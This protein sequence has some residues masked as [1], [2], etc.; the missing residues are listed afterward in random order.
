MLTCTMTETK[1][2]MEGKTAGIVRR[3]DGACPHEVGSQLVFASEYLPWAPRGEDG[4]RKAVP[5]ARGTIVSLRPGSV[6]QF[7]KDKMLAE[8]DGYANPN[9]W[10]GHLRQFYKGIP[11][12]ANV[13]HITFRLE[14]VDKEGPK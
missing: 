9:V 11:D 4:K 13:F 6:G 3:Y 14:E 12:D 7:R 1:L 5:F 8:T 10:H 2:I